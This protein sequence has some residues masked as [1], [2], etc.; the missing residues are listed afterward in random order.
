MIRLSIPTCLMLCLALAGCNASPWSGGHS[1]TSPVASAQPPA[2]SPAVP[3]TPAQ[4]AVTPVPPQTLQQLMDEIQQAGTL[5]PATQEKLLE[6]LRKTD[7]SLWPLV[8]QQFR[9]SA[10]YARQAQQKRQPAEGSPGLSPAIAASAASGTLPNATASADR[11]PSRLAVPR[12]QDRDPVVEPR[13]ADTSVAKVERLPDPSGVPLPPQSAPTGSYPRTDP[14]Q[15]AKQ[16]DP[17]TAPSPTAEDKPAAAK[18]A[19]PKPADASPIVPVKYEEQVQDWR[20]HL[21]ATI[22]AKEAEVKRGG[23]TAEDE[24]RQAQLRLL[25]MLAGRRDEALKPIPY[26]SPATQ[27][28]WTAEVYGL[29]AWLDTSRI[30]DATQRTS[31][32]RQHLSEALARLSEACA[33]MVRN[34]AF[35]S[36]VQSYGCIKRFDK[37]DFTPGQRVLLYAEVENFSSESTAQGYHTSLRSSYQIFDSRGQRVADEEFTMTEELCL[38]PR[39]D[40]FTGYVLRLPEQI[41]PGKHTLQLTIE[42]LKS[43]KIGQSSVEFTI[44]KSDRQ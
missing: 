22:R 3:S 4:T 40:Y 37:Y 2:P 38:N 21:D 13:A 24:V 9:A 27:A 19:D 12:D 36:E 35:C 17:A 44:K 6:D 28:F 32:A 23:K 29:S 43:R 39:R 33:L 25:Y 34:V 14:A 15:V 8:M 16:A 10:A 31:E 1:T 18:P 26:A 42:D 20:K 11:P 30:G 41:Y 5:D 7:P